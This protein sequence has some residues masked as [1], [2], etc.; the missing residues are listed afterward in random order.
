MHMLPS[1][2][3]YGI[4][5]PPALHASTRPSPTLL[6]RDEPTSGLDS[7]AAYYVMAAVRRLAEKCR[8][9]IK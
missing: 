1:A 4:P 9:I 6:I 7:A 3:A 8:T 2:T 5:Q